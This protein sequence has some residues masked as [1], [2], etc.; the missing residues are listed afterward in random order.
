MHACWHHARRGLRHHRTTSIRNLSQKRSDTVGEVTRLAESGISRALASPPEPCHVARSRP[1]PTHCP[2]EWHD[3]KAADRT[4]S[5]F[6]NGIPPLLRASAA[7]GLE[8]PP[9]PQRRPFAGGLTTVTEHC[10]NLRAITVMLD[11]SEAARTAARGGVAA[12]H[13]LTPGRAGCSLAWGIR[14]G[15]RSVRHAIYQCPPNTR[16]WI[17]S[18]SAWIRR[19]MACTSPTASTA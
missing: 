15:R 13:A 8:L 18:S 12:A 14:P 2:S 6:A 3:T 1:D 5:D 16:V 4:R 19:I 10:P 9:A 17:G 7:G 11:G